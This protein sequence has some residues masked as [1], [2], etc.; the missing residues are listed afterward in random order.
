[1]K[2]TK[3]LL[4]ILFLGLLWMAYEIFSFPTRPYGGQATIEVKKGMGIVSVVR[5]LEKAGLTDS[6]RKMSFYFRHKKVGAVLKAGEYELGPEATP[7]SI[8]E[9]LLRGERIRRTFTIPE[10]YNLREIAKLL[11]SKGLVNEQSFLQKVFAIDAASKM[12]LAGTTL[13]GFLFPDTYEY[14]K[15]MTEEELILMMVKNFKKHFD[16]AMTQ[17]I[18][19]MGWTQNQVITLASLIEKETSKDEERP[20]VASVFNNRLKIGMPLATD[21]SVIYGIPNYDGNIRKADLERPGPYNTYLLPGLPPTPIASPGLK[22]IQATLNPAVSDYLYF[23]SRNDGT[24]QFS[25]T[26]E[27]HNAAVKQY[28]LS[29]VPVK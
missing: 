7:Q 15:E 22:S 10:G 13:E 17:Q 26:L 12:G 4:L 11:V 1:M 19:T 20:F 14:S 6:P 5:E 25:K 27:E 16:A 29:K 3:I 21:P 2:F 28:Q 24:H 23:V 18:Q 9:K 8:A